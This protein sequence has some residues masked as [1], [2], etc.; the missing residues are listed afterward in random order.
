MIGC[1]LVDGNAEELCQ[2]AAIAAPPGD[3]A[4]GGDAFE[5]AD[6]DH[7]KVNARRDRWPTELGGIVWLAT[8]FDPL[9]ELGLRQELIEFL[10]E[11]MP[12]RLRQLRRGNPKPLL[13]SFAFPQ[14]HRDSS[15]GSIPFCLA[16]SIS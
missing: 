13:F 3:A 12:R 14:S 15:F 2:R 4:L 10:V 9:V 5:V 6:E 8:L 16:D 11:G 7:A 1:G